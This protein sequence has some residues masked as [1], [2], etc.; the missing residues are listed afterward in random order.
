MIIGFFSDAHGNEIGFNK[1]Y[2]FLT[3]NVDLIFYLGDICGYFPL[4]NKIINVLR[5]KN[6]PCLKGN[7][8][9]MLLGELPYDL[10]REPIYRVQESREI[11]SDINFNFLGK[12]KSELIL[13][14]DGK[15][16]LLVHGSPLDSI[17]GYVYPDNDLESF[18]K[19]PY[20][21][22]F[23][24]HTHRAFIKKSLGKVIVNVGSCGLPR[25]EGNKAT[26]VLYNTITHEAVIK[27]LEL[28]NE[29][30]FSKYKNEIH[31]SVKTVLN[32]NNKIF[33]K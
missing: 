12:L 8:E 26:V 9:A 30:V 31:L 22:I 33:N 27:E 24:G 16:L 7:H 3:S 29:E 2:N 23:M 19:L 10:S 18:V 1:C 28:D 32:R 20:N 4:S 25:D 13:S 17:N 5:E 11:I 14:I 15:R 21:A 6:I